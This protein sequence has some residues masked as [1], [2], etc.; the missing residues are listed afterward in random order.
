MRYNSL[1]VNLT[2][3]L[4]SLYYYSINLLK[5]KWKEE[6]LFDIIFRFIV[7]YVP[8]MKTKRGSGVW[9]HISSY[10]KYSEENCR[11]Q[12]ELTDVIKYAALCRITG[13]V[14]SRPQE[15][16]LPSRTCEFRS[17]EE[18]SPKFAY[19]L[20]NVCRPKSPDYLPIL[21]GTLDRDGNADSNRS[22]VR[23]VPGT[24]S[25]T[26]H[27]C[28]PVTWMMHHSFRFHSIWKMPSRAAG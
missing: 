6:M 5:W 27:F 24:N 11:S 10:C 4:W 25:L 22:G 12:G 23:N 14:S 26:A 21:L 13:L 17:T 18:M 20:R 28:S 15:C 16:T 19:I 2:G 3:N 1:W 8:L 7:M 9:Y